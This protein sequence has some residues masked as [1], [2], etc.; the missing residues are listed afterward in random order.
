MCA[1][2]YFLSREGHPIPFHQPGPAQVPQ[3]LP[4]HINSTPNN[5]RVTTPGQGNG[6]DPPRLA[7]TFD[8]NRVYH[9]FG[10]V[11]TGSQS[12][13]AHVHEDIR[14]SRTPSDERPSSSFGPNGFSFDM[15]S[16]APVSIKPEPE[17]EASSSTLGMGSSTPIPAL[18]SRPSHSRNSTLSQSRKHRSRMQRPVLSENSNDLSNHGMSC[19]DTQSNIS[20][21]FPTHID[22]ASLELRERQIFEILQANRHVP[23][24][25]TSS[26]FLRDESSGPPAQAE[27]GSSTMLDSE[28]TPQRRTIPSDPTANAVEPG[29]ADGICH[30][31]PQCSCVG[32]ATHP[33]NATAVATV[34]DLG[35][36][37]QDE[38]SPASSGAPHSGFPL[39][40]ESAS[41]SFSQGYPTG[42]PQPSIA[43]CETLEAYP[44][45]PMQSEIP[46]ME[47]D[48]LDFSADYLTF[49][50]PFHSC[51]DENGECP[52]EEDCTCV[53]CLTH[54][55][56]QAP[57]LDA[58]DTLSSEQYVPIPGFFEAYDENSS[59]RRFP[60]SHI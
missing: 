26:P 37:L 33:M 22:P 19:C 30:C 58:Q 40:V 45:H 12:N 47:G 60:A 41:N 7:P 6:A 13:N 9:N 57:M 32:C 42:L 53:G 29:C 8:A 51:T 28:V 49:Q 16:T 54:K 24:L 10:S 44:L 20:H 36:I 21:D 52:C 46:P 25:L 38:F 1:P 43:D 18:L 23:T 48:T 14:H 39:N 15:L 59:H 56:N 2:S 35:R 11:S 50:F 31:G 5:Y 34:Y 27:Q 17:D 55:E 3:P 4:S